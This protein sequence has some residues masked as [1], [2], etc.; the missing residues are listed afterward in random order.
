MCAW[1]FPHQRACSSS[2]TSTRRTFLEKV[3]ALI[4]AD[5]PPSLS[6]LSGRLAYHF[7]IQGLAAFISRVSGLAAHH[8]LFLLVVPMFVAGVIGRRRSSV[9]ARSRR[10]SPAALTAT[11]L[12]IA[13]PTD[14]L[15]DSLGRR[16]VDAVSSRTFEPLR[17]SLTDYELW[18]VAFN[19]AHNLAA[20]FLAWPASERSPP[21]PRMD[22]ASASS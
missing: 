12:L 20:H 22:G 1:A 5:P 6:V 2:S 16:L 9:V 11:M 7:G 19:N 21:P 4:R 8:S 17:S 18:N 14:P 13:V 10:R 15:W 3:H